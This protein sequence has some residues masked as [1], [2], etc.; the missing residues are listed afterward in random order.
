MKRRVAFSLLLVLAAAILSSHVSWQKRDNGWLMDIDGRPVDALGWLKE[1]ALRWS[2]D[3][4]DIRRLGVDDAAHAPALA[5]L[6]N[7]SP[8]AS[9]SARVNSMWS[10]GGWLLMEAEFDTLLPAVSLLRFDGTAWQVVPHG[11]WSGQTHP[12]MAAP[13]IRRYLADQVPQA[14]QGLLDCFEL[15]GLALGHGTVSRD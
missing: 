7:Y 5:T 3:C 4:R 9:L 11:I 10:S 12:W 14:P 6:K 15:Q 2:R 8:P 13:L 1:H